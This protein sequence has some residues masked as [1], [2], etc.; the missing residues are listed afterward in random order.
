M[1]LSPRSLPTECRASVS[2]SEKSPD[3]THPDQLEGSSTA[4]SVS[5][6]VPLRKQRMR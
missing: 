6:Y 1:R 3:I 2:M 5:I 4:K